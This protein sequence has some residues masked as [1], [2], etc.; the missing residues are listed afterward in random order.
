MEEVARQLGVQSIP[1]QEILDGFRRGRV[2]CERVE[3]MA[4][5]LLAPAR[6]ARLILSGYQYQSR[7]E[8][9]RLILAAVRAGV[10]VAVSVV[11]SI[12]LS[13]VAE[14]QGVAVSLVED[15]QLVLQ[16]PEISAIARLFHVSLDADA[17]A[18]V[19]Q[20]TCGS[21]RAVG[22]LLLR[23]AGVTRVR[24]TQERIEVGIEGAPEDR[25][26]SVAN[27]AAS[28]AGLRSVSAGAITRERMREALT[29]LRSDSGG[30]LELARCEQGQQGF[31][32]FVLR[33]AETGRMS[34]EAVRAVF[35]HSFEYV[36]RL[37][38]AG[39]ADVEFSGTGGGDFV[40]RPAA[41]EIF[42]DWADVLGADRE[43]R[44]QERVARHAVGARFAQWHA[45][46]GGIAEA[47]GILLELGDPEM[48]E[49]FA[50]RRF[51]DL[52]WEGQLEGFSSAFV[53]SD[54]GRE[55]RLASATL[56]VLASFPLCR[57]DASAARDAQ[58]LIEVISDLR[59][60]GDG[61]HQLST[62]LQLL[63]LIGCTRAWDACQFVEDEAEALVVQLL[64]EGSITETEAARSH[65]L[66]AII[67]YLRDRVYLSGQALQRVMAIGTTDVAHSIAVVVLAG[68]E[69]YV[70]QDL[71]PASASVEE[72]V[73]TLTREP[74]PSF[75][76]PETRSLIALS[77]FWCRFGEARFSD[78][79]AVIRRA[80]A[81]QPAALG[82][83]LVLWAYTVALLTTGQA[84]TANALYERIDAD[85]GV[86]GSGAAYSVRLYHLGAVLSALSAGKLE[87]ALHIVQSCGREGVTE[88]LTHTALAVCTGQESSGVAL[89][90]AA[91]PSSAYSHRIDEIIQGIQIASLVRAGDVDAA[92][93]LLRTVFGAAR[94]AD[95]MITGRFLSVEDVRLLAQLA[96]DA[97]EVELSRI[98]AAS[99][100]GPHVLRTGL[101][102]AELTQ[103]ELKVVR[104]GATWFDE[105][106]DCSRVLPLGKY[107]QDAPLSNLAEVGCTWTRSDCGT[108]PGTWDP[109][110]CAYPCPGSC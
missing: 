33:L 21:P 53:Q 97:G 78:S 35:G 23:L 24:A 100:Q 42:L 41:R 101:M 77:E 52:L 65:V 39:Y 22:A 84:Q 104:G 96:A 87:R 48:L 62:D 91:A 106:A 66:I 56:G 5:E 109:L 12:R 38:A 108:C 1:H 32:P 107:R 9:D 68:I 74:L 59:G 61:L 64:S 79:L 44:V 43:L 50:E 34:M 58:R 20:L 99:A 37:C 49:A 40:W 93:V 4:D 110:T 92:A 73:E 26:V 83:P 70:G 71:L 51:I 11:D 105:C 6:G 86:T 27:F 7:E 28:G 45:Q 29:M 16:G 19:Q 72:A 36:A 85:G 80:I 2:D 15:A 10:N 95:C 102:R 17:L 76:A 55:S 54:R 13:R 3:A 8:F 47:L 103:V 88:V 69:G 90:K 14:A 57:N 63:V 89:M 82:Q 30:M 60:Q 75:T 18:R 31:L 46:N 25:W 98:F 67:A 94:E 81:D